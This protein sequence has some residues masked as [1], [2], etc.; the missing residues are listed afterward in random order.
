[1]IKVDFELKAWQFA[2]IIALVC[3]TIFYWFYSTE[4]SKWNEALKF[5]QHK[6]EISEAKKKTDTA[7]IEYRTRVEKTNNIVQKWNTP[8][9]EYLRDT[10][11]L[12]CQNDI[13][14][15]DTTR[16]KCDTALSL[17]ILERSKYEDYIRALEKSKKKKLGIGVVV[18]PG[19]QIS[20]S[21]TISGGLQSTIGITIK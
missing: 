18:G 19:V 20:P 1:M 6:K 5:K 2:L 9:V 3:G 11:W 12:E 7:V 4:K 13:N 17:C 15:L 16:K 10:M 8:P 21:G 14:Y